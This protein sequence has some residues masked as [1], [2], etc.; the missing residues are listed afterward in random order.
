MLPMQIGAPYFSREA[1]AL[2]EL[3]DELAEFERITA[4]IGR[5]TETALALAWDTV[6]PL[7]S[8]KEHRAGSFYAEFQKAISSMWADLADL[9]VEVGEFAF[10]PDLKFSNYVADLA[11][12]PLHREID[13][14]A[15][16]LGAWSKHDIY[17]IDGQHRRAQ[18][19]GY[20][21]QKKRREVLTALFQE[22][23]LSIFR[24][25][26]Y[27]SNKERIVLNALHNRIREFIRLR[28]RT[29]H[30]NDQQKFCGSP[31]SS[32]FSYALRTGCPPPEVD[33]FRMQQST[34]QFV[35][36]NSALPNLRFPLGRSRPIVSAHRRSLE[37][38]RDASGPRLHV[39]RTFRR[40]RNHLAHPSGRFARAALRVGRTVRCNFRS[41][42]VGSE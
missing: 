29:I 2:A 27:C 11:N 30:S 14:T 31:R 12:A 3:V 35:G 17:L 15:F 24:N 9:Q 6:E 32:I 34:P 22:L 42:R 23:D 37:S 5:G 25:D 36:E 10:H 16:E 8:T 18:V 4:E 38:L 39:R 7:R 41:P 28:V 26:R 33:C 21:S 40:E 13:L 19:D 1:E 20:L